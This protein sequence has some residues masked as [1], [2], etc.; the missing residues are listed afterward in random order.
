MQTIMRGG[1]D[2]VLVLGVLIADIS[3]H[4]CPMTS[5]GYPRRT[6]LCDKTR[7]ENANLHDGPVHTLL[8]NLPIYTLW[9]RNIASR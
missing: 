1:T 6:C 8:Q 7:M 4:G 5:T 9:R 2:Q 3:P